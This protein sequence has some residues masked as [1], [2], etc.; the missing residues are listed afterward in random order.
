ME[1]TRDL[2]QVQNMKYAVNTATRETRNTDEGY[3]RLA[4]NTIQMT[5]KRVFL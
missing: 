2:R 4:E 1:A 3:V 5:Y